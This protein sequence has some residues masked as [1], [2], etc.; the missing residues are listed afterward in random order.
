MASI[1]NNTVN[2]MAAMIICGACNGKMRLLTRSDNSSTPI[3][4]T[5]YLFINYAVC[6]QCGSRARI[7]TT[8]AFI[9]KPLIQMDIFNK[10]I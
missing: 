10:E 6:L 1:N 9:G 5:E 3:N 4:N 8:V 2:M 7:Q